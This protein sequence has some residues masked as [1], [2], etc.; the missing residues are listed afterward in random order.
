VPVVLGPS[1]SITLTRSV[2]VAVFVM[3][4]M[5]TGPMVVTSLIHHFHHLR[6]AALIK[7]D[8]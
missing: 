5:A 4:P 6:A 7:H 1:F 8:N 3:V 2:I